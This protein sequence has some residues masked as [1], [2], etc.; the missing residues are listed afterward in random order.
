MLFPTLTF[1][2]FF[3]AVFLGIWA[4]RE[5]EWRKILLLVASWIFYGAW[6][7]RF[8]ALLIASGVLNWGAARLI[9]WTR[10]HGASEHCKAL[11]KPIFI[12][13]IIA[14]LVILGFFKYYGFFLEQVGAV[15][16]SVGWE[17][18]LTIMSVILPVGVSFFTFQGMS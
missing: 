11:A 13:G 18:D 9:L 7:W 2:L 1:H 4:V 14:N 17:R 15:L 12:L 5:N 3:I 16:Y 10:E 6:D 8:V